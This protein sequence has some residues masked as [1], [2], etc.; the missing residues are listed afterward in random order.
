MPLPNFIC[1]GA[2]K[3]G[4]TPLSLIL[5]QHRDIFIPRQKETRFFTV[6]YPLQ[7][8][9][10]YE[11]YF[12]NGHLDQK[13]VGELTPDYM[14]FPE[15]PERLREAL[16]PDLKLIFCLREPL[17]RA[18]SH[19]LQCV[20]IMEEGDSFENAVA[21]EPQRLAQNRHLGT[22]RAYLGG[23]LYA[24]QIARFLEHFAR[25]NMFFM[26][27]EEDFGA[28]RARTM[29]RL[30]DFLGVGADPGVNLRVPSTS[31]PAPRIRFVGE[32]DE[33][34]FK[35]PRRG[36][37]LPPGAILFTTGNKPGDRVIPRPSPA[38]VQHFRT[39]Q[40]RMTRTLPEAFA[41]ELYRRHFRDEIGRVEALIGRELSVWR[42]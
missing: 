8:L 37:D 20:R 41:E 3:A 4:T 21:L 34:H 39:L 7:T 12:F 9:V 24:G 10:L 29:A 38:T 40:E 19:Y 11:T 6:L 18:F 28:A 1:V 32:G 30:F 14:R 5:R 42:R 15:V 33:I 25:E 27:L 2:E 26:V 22:R 17:A 23:S 13:A 31:L 35:T 16:G 36:I